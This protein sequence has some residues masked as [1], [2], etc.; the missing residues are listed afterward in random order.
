MPWRERRLPSGTPGIVLQIGYRP[1]GPGPLF[2]LHMLV[3]ACERKM[4]FCVI[5][6]LGM[7]PGRDGG[8]AIGEVF[9][10]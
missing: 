9:T 8:L 2:L 1:T 3:T 7:F 10:R 6:L 4:S 5:I